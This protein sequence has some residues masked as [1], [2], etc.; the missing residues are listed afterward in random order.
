MLISWL[1]SFSLFRLTES[2][3]VWYD[4]GAYIQ[5]AK[6]TVEYGITGLRLSPEGISHISKLTV[7]Y[8]LIYPLTAVFKVFGDSVASARNLMVLFTIGLS[9]VSYLCPSYYLFM[10]TLMACQIF[11]PKSL[12][13]SKCS[14]LVAHHYI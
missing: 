8:P 11:M 10:P 1:V 4:E 3:S 2:P 12:P 7:G 5:L 13:I 6:N 9:V 14:S